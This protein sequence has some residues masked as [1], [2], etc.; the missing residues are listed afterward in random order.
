LKTAGRGWMTFFANA[1]DAR[2]GLNDQQRRIF[3]K[4]LD[5]EM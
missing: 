5:T 1:T 2:Q 3:N 4:G